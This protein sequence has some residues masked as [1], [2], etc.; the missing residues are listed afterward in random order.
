[1]QLQES[2]PYAVVEVMRGSSLLPEATVELFTAN[3][4]AWAGL[5][6]SEVKTNLLFAAGQ[7]SQ[8]VW[9]PLRND[10]L[11]EDAET[12]KVQ[13]RRASGFP[14]HYSDLALSVQ[15]QDNDQGF[16]V[17]PT[18]PDYG[19]VQED[20]AL[21]HFEVALV[22]DFDATHAAAVTVA[23]RDDKTAGAVAGQDYQAFEARL[24][25]APGERVKSF[26]IAILND[27]LIEGLEGFP[28]YLSE[29]EGA[30]LSRYQ[31]WTIGTIMDNECGYR[32]ND[33]EEEQDLVFHEGRKASVTI[34]RNGEFN[35]NSSVTLKLTSTSALFAEVGSATAGVDFPITNVLV[36]FGPGQSRKAVTFDLPDE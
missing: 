13:L 4:K 9:I 14:L 1:M 20:Q 19:R 34:Q 11:R 8:F 33:A 12:F 27:I 5:D 23:T 17:R 29:P 18:A 10:A 22:G 6:Y 3:G 7:T 28:L 16:V 31:A 21:M 25:F 26:S 24:V 36:E 35:F 30:P 2:E 15:I 32:F